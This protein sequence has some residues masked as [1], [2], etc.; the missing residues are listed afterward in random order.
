GHPLRQ[1]GGAR[2]VP[3]ARRR[4]GRGP[5]VPRGPGEVHVI[6]SRIVP[7]LIVAAL[8]VILAGKLLFHV[9]V[10]PFLWTYGVLVTLVTFTTFFG[11]YRYYTDPAKDPPHPSV[12]D[13]RPK[14]SC[15]IPVKN[16]ERLITR[17][18]TSVLDQTYE[19][20]EVIV[21]DDGS[22]DRTPAILDGLAATHPG[23][24]V[25]HLP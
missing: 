10:D 15:I 14:V 4:A 17:W 24:R 1:I 13:L 3:P 8:A 12:T 2:G 11:A 23:V 9:A 22:T 20:L 19:H 25:V 21:V 7:A 16:E 5:V 18:V 6:R